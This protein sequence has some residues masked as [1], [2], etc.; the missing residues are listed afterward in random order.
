MINAFIVSKSIS[1]APRTTELH[2]PQTQKYANK[3]LQRDLDHQ[4]GD[5]KDAVHVIR[6][7]PLYIILSRRE[8]IN[9]DTNQYTTF[10]LGKNN[11]PLFQKYLENYTSNQIEI[12]YSHKSHP[13]LL[14]SQC[15]PEV[16]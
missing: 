3:S 16:P 2:Y 11:Y 7:D 4:G 1:H 6:T 10:L 15:K 9:V 5:A 13:N 8:T 14:K 12:Y